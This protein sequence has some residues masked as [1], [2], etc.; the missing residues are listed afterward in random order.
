[1]AHDQAQ[2]RATSVEVEGKPLAE[3]IEEVAPGAVARLKPAQRRKVEGAI[4]RGNMPRQEIQ[5]HSGPLPPP[6]Q[7]A[8]YE[9]LLPGAVERIMQMAE[10]QAAHR[11]SLEQKAVSTQ[12]KES[13]R[14]QIFGLIIAL[15]GIGA[16]LTAILTGHDWAGGTIGTA[17]LVSLVSVFVIGKRMQARSLEEKRPPA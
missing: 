11:M 7:L 6:E 12:L 14:G 15:C 17:S 10:R 16:S 3:V 8:A 4:I 2:L 1:M 5:F 9:R 13:G